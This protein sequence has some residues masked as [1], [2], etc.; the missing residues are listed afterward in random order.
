MRTLGFLQG[1]LHQNLLGKVLLASV[2]PISLRATSS[3]NSSPDCSVPLCICVQIPTR[4]CAQVPGP[5]GTHVTPFTPAH[6][7][8]FADKATF[9]AMG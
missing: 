5:I 9:W 2:N 7:H 4:A 1:G 3:I 8:L 6:T